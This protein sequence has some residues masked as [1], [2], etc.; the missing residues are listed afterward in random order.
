MNWP[1]L[2]AVLL[3]ICSVMAG[4]LNQIKR[5]VVLILKKK[6]LLLPIDFQLE[7]GVTTQAD[8]IIRTTILNC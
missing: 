5:T 4:K 7:V 8:F 6:I 2:L 3:R 1:G